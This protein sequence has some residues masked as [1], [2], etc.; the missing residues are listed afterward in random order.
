MQGREEK[1]PFLDEIEVF[2]DLGR[3]GICWVFVSKSQTKFFKKYIKYKKK[4]KNVK[5]RL[6]V[7]RRLEYLMVVEWD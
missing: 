7:K 5:M 2:G 3:G 4:E 6:V 1:G